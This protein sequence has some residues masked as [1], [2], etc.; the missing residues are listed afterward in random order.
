M[1]NIIII[2]LFI[3][4]WLTACESKDNTTVVSPDGSIVA[5]VGT[6]GGKLYYTITKNNKAV[7]NKSFLGFKLK[8]SEWNKDFIITGVNHSSFDETWEQP[9]GEEVTVKNKYNQLSVDV[10]ENSGLKR[11]FTLVFRV[12]DD[13]MGFRYEFPEQENLNDFIIMDE[14]TEFALADNHKTSKWLADQLG[15]SDMTVSRWCTNRSQPSVHQLIKI[16][17]LLD[18][19]VSELLNKTK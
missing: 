4:V 13:G 16:A 6:D 2:F 15:K 10:E 1:K 11:K 19:D 18:V 14:L 8:D 9:W 3:L 7:I 17:N 12:F 5:S